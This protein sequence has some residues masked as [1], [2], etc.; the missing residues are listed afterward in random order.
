MNIVD[1]HSH[2]YLHDFDQDRHQ[3]I[4][5][6]KQ[7]GVSCIIMPNIDSTSIDSLT[8][9]ANQYKG[10]CIPLMGLHPTSVKDNFEQELLIVEKHLSTKNFYGVGEIGIDLYWDKTHITQQREAF[11]FQ[12]RLAKKIGLPIVIHSRDA[13]HEIFEIIDKENDKSLK[14]VF[15]SFSGTFEQYMHV[16]SYGGFKVGIGGVVTYKNGGL[17]KVVEQMN[18]E[19]I[20]LE[21]DSPY[22][23]PVPMRGKRNES[24]NLTYIANKVAAIM[25]IPVERVAE[26]T[27]KNARDLFLIE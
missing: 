20:V 6:A 15:H 1:T 26:I 12:I 16:L 3:V 2:I 4:V 22:L 25:N 18:I 11:R 13:F 24:S 27:T 5:R 19:H 9:V 21:T 14:G 7:A 17:D 8:M 10:Y 23:S